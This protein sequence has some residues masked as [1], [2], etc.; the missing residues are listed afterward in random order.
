M[1]TLLLLLSSGRNW[2]RNNNIIITDPPFSV[3]LV[4]AEWSAACYAGVSKV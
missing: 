1:L 2:M 3:K 4:A